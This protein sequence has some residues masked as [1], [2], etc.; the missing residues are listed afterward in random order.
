M[1]STCPGRMGT[2]GTGCKCNPFRTVVHTPA[3][4]MVHG[5]STAGCSSTASL[6]GI[7]T[8]SGT[9][10]RSSWVGCSTAVVFRSSKAG[11]STAGS[12]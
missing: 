10:S 11:C 12:I 1:R 5:C 2:A 9:A 3:V 4:G 6:V 7:G 8:G